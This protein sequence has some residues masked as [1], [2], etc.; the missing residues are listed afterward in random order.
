MYAIIISSQVSRIGIEEVD[1]QYIAILRYCPSTSG[2]QES[3]LVCRERWHCLHTWWDS[4]ITYHF[5]D[6]ILCPYI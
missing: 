5:H 1:G 3:E 2:N 4:H 6:Y